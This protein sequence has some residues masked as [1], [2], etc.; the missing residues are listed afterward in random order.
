M[1]PEFQ[2]RMRDPPSPVSAYGQKYCAEW[3]RAPAAQPIVLLLNPNHLWGNQFDIYFPAGGTRLVHMGRVCSEYEHEYPYALVELKTSSTILPPASRNAWILGV[4]FT[5]KELRFDPSRP[6]RIF[7]DLCVG[8]G[9][10]NAVCVEP[11]QWDDWPKGADL[12]AGRLAASGDE[13]RYRWAEREM[14]NVLLDN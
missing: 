6:V 8:P 12:A 1:G 5:T 9:R 10:F 2:D 13:V 14:R 7:D 3:D 4:A 11:V